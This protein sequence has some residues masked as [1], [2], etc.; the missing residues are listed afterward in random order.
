MEKTL[1]KTIW[2]DDIRVIA[3]LAVIILHVASPAVFTEYKS[4]GN[5][6][7]NW[8]IANIYNS[9]TRFCVPLFIMVTGALLLPQQI[10]L[11]LFLQKRLKRIVLPFVF[12]TA[13]YVVFNFGL[14]IRD[15]GYSGINDFWEWLFV[16]LIQGPSVHLWYVYMIIGLYLFVPIIKPWIQ[17]ASNQAILYFLGIWLVTVLVNQLQIITIS[18]PFDISYFS[19]YLGYLILGYYLAERAIITKN[20]KK[21]SIIT[22][23]LGFL[24]T[25][26]GT[27]F[28]SKQSNSFSEAFYQYLTLNVVFAS[29][30]MFVFIKSWKSNPASTRYAAFRT[31]INK[32]GFGIYLGHVLIINIL[33]YFN[34]DYRL[35]T[36]WLSIPFVAIVCLILTCLMIYILDKLPYGK[37]IA[38]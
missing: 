9:F 24:A 36:P 23:I 30:G 38:R 3:T 22:F 2:I 25:L 20:L 31:F 5:S 34:I 29:F 16:Q 26:I 8:W 32:Y 11:N 6:N 19:G 21:I 17:Q 14:K 27:Y 33:S 1:Q 4:L 7:S 35:F 10:G 18:S 28:A 37:Y 13:V 12:W 15:F